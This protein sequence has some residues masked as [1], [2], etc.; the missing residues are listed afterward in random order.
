MSE[1]IASADS[2]LRINAELR[3]E[4]ARRAEMDAEDTHRLQTY[5]GRLFAENEH[6]TQRQFAAFTLVGRLDYFLET[7]ASQPA[8]THK[9]QAAQ[10][11]REIEQLVTAHLVT[12]PDS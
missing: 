3:R 9:K 12:S 11:R 1:E 2:L 7:Y 5:C 8:A 10:L 4:M 6:L